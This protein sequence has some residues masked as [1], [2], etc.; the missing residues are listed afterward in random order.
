MEKGGKERNWE[1]E[2]WE[3][4]EVKDDLKQVFRK[5]AR[6]WEKWLKAFQKD[7]EK[8]MKR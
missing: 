5:G 4:S 2:Q 6:E 1:D 7:P 3:I 8:A